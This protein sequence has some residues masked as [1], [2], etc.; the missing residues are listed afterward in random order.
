MTKE[1]HRVPLFCVAFCVVIWYD[2][3][4]SKL[5]ME[6]GGMVVFCK[7]CGKEIADNA[8]MCPACGAPTDNYLPSTSNK[9]Q[10]SVTRLVLGII[11]TVL[12]SISFFQSCTVSS[13]EIAGEALGEEN[14]NAGGSGMLMALL[15]LAGGIV[16][17]ATRKGK[18]GGIVSGS[19]MI[20]AGITGIGAGE[21]FPDL[22]FYGVM[23]FAFGIACLVVSIV[24]GGKGKK[25]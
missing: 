14:A 24:W 7:K 15:M 16:A 19:L 11:A 13:L 1:R 2:E 21:I 6:M 8:I 22:Y 10:G 12:G 17:I 23:A 4:N 9:K 5:D 25:I 3:E 20:F 18:A